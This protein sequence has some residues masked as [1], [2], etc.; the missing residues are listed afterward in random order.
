[1]TERRRKILVGS[2][3]FLL[4]MGSLAA[5]VAVGGWPNWNHWILFSVA[6]VVL[7][8]RSVEVN[9]HLEVSSSVMALF[10]GGVVFALDESSSAASG[11][12]LM[13]VVGAIALEDLRSRMVF[14]FVG[15]AS[16]M[17]IAGVAAGWVLDLTVTQ[18][19][20]EMFRVAIWGAGAALVFTWLNLG[21]VRMVVRSVCGTRDLMPWSR[22]GMLFLTQSTMGLVGGILGWILVSSAGRQSGILP[23]VLGVFVIAQMLFSAFSGIRAAHED[24]LRGFVKTLEA[25]DLYMRGH[26]ERVARFTR[27]MCDFFKFSG[28][29][30]ERMHWAALIHDVGKLAA[31]VELME[32]DGILNDDQYRRFRAATHQVDDLLSGVEFLRPVVEIASGCHT[33]LPDEDF[34]QTGHSHTTDPT[35][36]QKILAVADAFDAITTNRSYRMAS[37]QRAA[38]EIMRE[39]D[40]PLMDGEVIDALEESLRR[41]G[42]TYGPPDLEGRR[43]SVEGSDGH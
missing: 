6:L 9:D 10:T 34:G 40:T 29:Q 35:L 4:G 22:M 33:R 3:L 19:D 16:Q 8:L 41:A 43:V 24:A 21:L 25:R 15:N 26:T 39:A 27:M 5:A 14:R 32:H 23:L 11:M 31:P 13:C 17:A 37:S 1:M 30:T 28:T 18:P 12:G 38:F 7:S 36:E 2:V 20:V 42:E